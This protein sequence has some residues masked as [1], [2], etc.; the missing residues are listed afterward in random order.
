[1][2]PL[3]RRLICVSFSIWVAIR[4]ST[5]SSVPDDSPAS[6]MATK[7][8]LNTFGCRA[9]AAENTSPA[10]T[11]ARTSASTSARYLSSVCS[12]RVT[13]AATT[14]TPASIIVA[15]WREKTWSDFCLTFLKTARPPSP[16]APFSTSR[17]GSSPRERSC[18]RAA[19]TSGAWTSPLSSKPWA[20]IASYVYA[21]IR[22]SSVVEPKLACRLV[23]R[24]RFADENLRACRAV[25]DRDRHQLHRPVRNT[26][27]GGARRIR[28]VGRVEHRARDRAVVLGVD[29]HPVRAAVRPR[30]RRRR[31]RDARYRRVRE[32]PVLLH[33]LVGDRGCGRRTARVPEGDH[34]RAEAGDDREDPDRED[35]QRDQELDQLKAFVAAQPPH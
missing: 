17:C 3:T 32:P 18:S 15:S 34:A 13:S 24:R 14:L 25:A 10:S 28:R 6:T 31:L 7:R 29:L 12:S 35:R 20:L 9:S 1:M 4:S 27:D 8:R 30:R 19:A 33:L 11:S 22:S 26:R 23:E 5:V 21:A 2:A 16:D